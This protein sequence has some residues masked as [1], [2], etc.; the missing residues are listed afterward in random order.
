MCLRVKN[1]SPEYSTWLNSGSWGWGR[2]HSS[3]GHPIAKRENRN[4]VDRNH[5]CTHRFS[6]Q[7]MGGEAIVPHFLHDLWSRSSPPFRVLLSHWLEL[8]WP[9]FEMLCVAAS[10]FFENFSDKQCTLCGGR[11]FDRSPFAS[12]S[13]VLCTIA[14]STRPQV[15]LPPPRDATVSGSRGGH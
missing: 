9:P 15:T 3:V 14:W 1:V 13:R 4:L 2:L 10:G 11:A 8:L 7:K 6:G 5:I 12:V